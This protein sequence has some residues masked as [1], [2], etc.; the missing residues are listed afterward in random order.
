MGNWRFSVLQNKCRLWLYFGKILTFMS[1]NLVNYLF[2]GSQF[3]LK[4]VYRGNWIPT[5]F[6]ELFQHFNKKQPFW[7]IQQ[8]KFS[9]LYL[10]LMRIA[11]F[12][13][14]SHIIMII[15]CHLCSVKIKQITHICSFRKKNSQRY[16]VKT[17]AK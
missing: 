10:N 1:E 13:F 9:L 14:W 6:K 12:T 3:Q 7:R 4:L 11:V 15:S 8:C 5:T 2:N 17:Q 16:E